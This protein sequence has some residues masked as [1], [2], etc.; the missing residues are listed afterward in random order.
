MPRQSK[1]PSPPPEP[2]PRR[3]SKSKASSA[4]PPVQTQLP[5]PFP[6]ARLSL[7]DLLETLD[8][9][10]RAYPQ[11]H[12]DLPDYLVVR[13]ICGKKHRGVYPSITSTQAKQLHATYLKLIQPPKGTYECPPPSSPT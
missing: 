3:S 13:R 5:L 2:S 8:S 6:A 9:Y 11:V 7:P 10:T 4:A 1:E 12:I